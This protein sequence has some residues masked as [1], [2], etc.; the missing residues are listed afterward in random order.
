MPF[1]IGS[2]VRI[3]THT[4]DEK[5]RYYTG[6]ARH[7]DEFE[8]QIGTLIDVG[9]TAH[10]GRVWQIEINDQSHWFLEDSLSFVDYDVF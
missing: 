1:K 8:G 6:W 4:N 3:R 9:L 7:M 2:E 10:N 5:R